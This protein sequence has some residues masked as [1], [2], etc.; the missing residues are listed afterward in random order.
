MRAA[1]RGKKDGGKGAIS[2][3]RN[4]ILHTLLDL[5]EDN[6]R[7]FMDLCF[8]ELYT[9][10]DIKNNDDVYQYIQSGGKAPAKNVKELQAHIEMIHAIIGKLGQLMEMNLGYVLRTIVW[11]GYIVDELNKTSGKVV[12]FKAVRNSVYAKLSL[13][14]SKF[15]GFVYTPSAEETIFKVSRFYLNFS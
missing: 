3:R 15:N 13:F 4:L 12:G 7:Y 6:I 10:S 2:A 9:G 1:K 5:S 8:G 14:F 11:I